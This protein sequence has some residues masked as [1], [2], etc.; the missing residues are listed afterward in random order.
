[1]RDW[2]SRDK[3]Y[4]RGENNASG[5]YEYS[6][7]EHVTRAWHWLDSM[8]QREFT[9]A[10][11]RLDDIFEK[12]RRVVENG[13]EKT[14]EERIEELQEKQAA[15][16]REITDIRAGKAPYRPF[17]SVRIQ[18]EYDGLLEQLRAL[19]TDFKIVE[20]NFERIRTDILRR[21]AAEK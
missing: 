19:S 10:R 4:L 18:E 2:E 15:L 21:Q 12:I 1:M 14:D 16:K 17:D 8:E 20:S 11:S 9:G 13:R 6:L 7:T 5:R 3:R